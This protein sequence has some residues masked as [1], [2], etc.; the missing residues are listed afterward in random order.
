MRALAT[1]GGFT[2]LLA[3][4]PPP[5]GERSVGG[6]VGSMPA[7]VIAALV[8]R[9]PGRVWVIASEDPKEGAACVQDL[10]TLLG[11]DAAVLYPAQEGRLTQEAQ[12]LE[13]G[14]ARIEALAQTLAGKT[15]ILAAPW[16]ALQEAAPLPREISG[17]RT[18][19]RTGDE[20]P[21]GR[22]TG[23]LEERGYRAA[24]MVEAVGEYAVRG[25]LVDLYSFGAAGPARIE[26]WGD[27]VDSLRRFEIQSQRSTTDLASIDILPARLQRPERAA[28]K[29]PGAPLLQLIPADSFLVQLGASAWEEPAA[30]RWEHV[31]RRHEET[32]GRVQPAPPP[33]ELLIDPARLIRIIS[34]F[35]RLRL[36]PE[37]GGD[38]S[39]EALEP[40]A[41]ERDTRKLRS[42]LQ[43]RAQGGE[44]SLVLCDNLGQADRLEEL[45]ADA[46]GR[47][48]KGCGLH[49]GSLSGGFLLPGA[50]PPTN[51]LVDHEI[52]AR[53][54]RLRGKRRFRG[55]VAFESV[56]QL[57]PGDYVVHMEHGIGRFLEMK[58]T[59]L[60]GGE[61]ESMLIEYAGGDVL[62]LPVQGL[63][64][65]ERWRGPTPDSK[66]KQ[67][68][69]LGG[70]R[71]GTLRKKTEEEIRKL[72]RELLDL[73]AARKEAKGHAYPPDTRWQREMEASFPYEETPDQLRAAREI[74]RDMESPAI[75][76]RLLVGDVGY[77]KTEVA[78]RAAFKAAQ[79]G[80]QVAM[81]APTTVLVS[82]HAESFQERLASFPLL[83]RP[84]SRL[85]PARTQ[86][87]T[88][89]ELADGR[90]DI[91]VG[92]HRMLSKDV[93]FRDLGLLIID[94]EQRLGVRQKERLKRLKLNVDV[95]SLT[96]TPIP[97]TLHLSLSGLRDLSLIETPPRDRLP[98]STLVLEWNEQFIAGACRR[99]L[100]R[101]GQVFYLHNRVETIQSAREMVQRMVPGARIEVAHGQMPPAQ[102]D[103]AM[104]RFME[105]SVEILVCS[106][107][108]EN[109]IDVPNANTLVVVGADRFGLSQLYQIRGRVG[110]SDRRAFCYLV[111]PRELTAD[112]ERRLRI[113]EQHTELGSGYRI[114]MRDLEIRGAGD[115]LGKDQS[116][117]AQSVGMDAY[118]RMLSQAVRRMKSARVRE[119]RPRPDVAMDG[120]AYLSDDYLGTGPQ[121]LH[122]Y[123]KLSR[124][125]KK[126]EVLEVEAE[127][128]DRFGA[129]PGSALR[130]IHQTL[131]AVVGRRTSVSSVLVRGGSAR[132]N[133]LPDA[134]ISILG[135]EPALQGLETR[136]DVRRA[137]P[138]SLVVHCPGRDQ[139]IKASVR[140]MEAIGGSF[141]GALPEMVAA[142]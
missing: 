88:I 133:F 102:L 86:R 3:R 104:H 14:G 10:K 69:R 31:A 25:G 49:A 87:E 17:F 33:E 130:L 141:S 32:K 92:T 72:T 22:L 30:R 112:A 81:L 46:R 113:L 43:G 68:H 114:A 27:T 64:Q 121:K 48:P 58:R 45:I 110:R 61:I 74:K 91:L 37:L 42:W 82:Q 57:R 18:V 39:F 15:P 36:Y 111:A 129:L 28:A 78:I 21:L 80:K 41:I 105:G 5:G 66:P 128:R 132:I 40:P 79:N 118:L 62:R 116:G 135:L 99:E 123:R 35:T 23:L 2:E 117:F 84:L 115:I 50:D 4:F 77:G 94:E 89:R 90:V 55:A 95:L 125:V 73:Y 59:V 103:G 16:A 26:L 11:D 56:A 70:R 85:Q 83:I 75:M 65:I 140:A 20:L 106:T 1:A 19:V 12:D 54:R 53:R 100:D 122:F 96:A 137:H 63:D 9:F 52:F 8:R 136:V 138:L 134:A 101:G 98:I 60:R 126:E 142:S 108:I 127:L 51:V 47:L 93:R 13:I 71:W 76:D 34:D 97:R 24:Q 38:L 124:L 109:G 120:G 67:L 131:L 6:M 44:R 7:V 119:D 107:I 29:G 139:L